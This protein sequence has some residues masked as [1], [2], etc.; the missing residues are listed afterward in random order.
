MNVNMRHTHV[1]PYKFMYIQHGNKS[2]CDNALLSFPYWVIMFM[3][4]LFRIPVRRNH[5]YR[6]KREPSISGNHQ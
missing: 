5:L 2:I 3:P 4:S 1:H 6:Q